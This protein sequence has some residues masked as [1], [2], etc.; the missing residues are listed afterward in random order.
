[1]QYGSSA[2]V[3]AGKGEHG[4]KTWAKLPAKTV[5]PRQPEK[6]YQDLATRI[7]ENRLLEL[8]VDT[9]L[10]LKRNHPIDP[11][12]Q[13]EE[14]SCQIG[15]TDI[16]TRIMLTQKLTAMEEE[17]PTNLDPGITEVIRRTEGVVFPLTVYQEASFFTPEKQ[18]L[19]ASPNYRSG[20]PWRDWVYVQYENNR[21]E[22]VYY[23]YQI[24][25]FFMRNEEAYAIGKMGL[26]KKN[27]S[28]KLMDVW[29]FE[30]KMRLVDLQTVYTSP[31]VLAVPENCCL[32]KG[33][34]APDRFFVFKDRI[35]DWPEVFLG[36]WSVTT[37]TNTTRNGKKR[38][39]GV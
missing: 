23:P 15:G 35:A 19:R 29:V 3:D 32:E 13:L 6:Y 20:G 17:G 4:L 16:Q 36:P 5:R 11:S 18:T 8:A 14:S 7:Y 38:K 28:S 37:T 30:A 9:L 12:M 22:R 24:F 21:G 39:V 10:P 34:K 31:F 1:V 26:R 27:H 2:N 25:G 33:T